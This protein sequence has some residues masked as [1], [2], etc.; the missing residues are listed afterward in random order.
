MVRRQGSKAF[1]E[2]LA[3]L[4]GELT[5]REVGDAVGVSASAVGQWEKGVTTPTADK[6][7]ALEDYFVVPGELAALLG[8]GRPGPVSAPRPGAPVED[9]LRSLE[10]R[11][12]RLEGKL[13]QV[14]DRFRAAEGSQ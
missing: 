10:V 3:Q 9:R 14:L 7:F 8:F 13:D 11:L 1:G 12:G 6:V 2:R 5:Q 4:R